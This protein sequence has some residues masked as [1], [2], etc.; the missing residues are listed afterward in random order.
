MSFTKT[1]NHRNEN[2]DERCNCSL[3]I[4]Y[5]PMLSEYISAAGPSLLTVTVWTGLVMLFRTVYNPRY[6]RKV[7]VRI[8]RDGKII[9]ID[10]NMV[11]HKLVGL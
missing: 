3:R 2:E 9:Q 6:V 1:S 11:L 10:L 7:S 5:C 4:S 8:I